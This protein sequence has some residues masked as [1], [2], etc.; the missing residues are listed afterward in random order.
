MARKD[1][2]TEARKGDSAKRTQEANLPQRLQEQPS[3]SKRRPLTDEEFTKQFLASIGRDFS[4]DLAAAIVLSSLLENGLMRLIDSRL[5]QLKCGR[6]KPCLAGKRCKKNDVIFSPKGGM[7]GFDKCAELAL[8]MGI[9]NSKFRENLSVIASIRNR[10]AHHP[11][12][13]D[14]NDDQIAKSCLELYP[15][16]RPVPR[17]VFS[18]DHPFMV[19]DVEY[20]PCIDSAKPLSGRMRFESIA[21]D[22]ITE[23]NAQAHAPNRPE[24][25]ERKTCAF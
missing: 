24:M 6:C 10:F 21:S 11:G 9:I 13:I 18:D 2:K 12:V 22:M 4:G 17:E 3:G 15:A 8:R 23:M 14:F 20:G 5:V 1:K 25:P 16:L 19:D 7:D